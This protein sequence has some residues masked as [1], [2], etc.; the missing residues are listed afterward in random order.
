LYDKWNTIARALRK[1]RANRK[2]NREREIEIE[3]RKR[4]ARVIA[5]ETSVIDVD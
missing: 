4:G 1:E 5:T 2:S 3:K